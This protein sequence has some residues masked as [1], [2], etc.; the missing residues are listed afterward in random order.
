ML[1]ALAE[2][3]IKPDVILGTSVGAINGA[4]FAAD[5]TLGGVERL[6]ELWRESNWSER[7][8]G[9][10]LR[11]LTTLARSGTHLESLSEM[12]E[13]LVALLPVQRVEELAGAVPVRG[14]VDRARRGALVRPRPAGRRGSGL[15]RGAR[16][17]CR[18]CRSTASTS[19]TAGSSTRSRSA[20]RSPSARAR[21]TCS[22]SAASSSPSSLRGGPG[23]S[24]WSPSRWRAATGSPTICTT[25]RRTSSYTS[26]PPAGRPRRPTT[27]FPASC[28]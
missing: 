10:A 4:F 23:R 27:I 19:S 18:R 13:R 21:S 14:G 15:L 22:R 20:A 16:A 6:S 1:R 12:R 7:S 26:S 11:R 2:R 8:A 9:A 24:G 17:S 25:C 3:D 28:G 5:P